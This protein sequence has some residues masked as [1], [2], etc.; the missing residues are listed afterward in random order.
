MAYGRLL[1]LFRAKLEFDEN[2]RLVRWF[3][4]QCEFSWLGGQ[5]RGS[6][7]RFYSIVSIPFVNSE[8]AE[9]NFWKHEEAK[10]GEC[11]GD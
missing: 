5:I 6:F 9:H 11:T 4:W 7:S 3:L 1:D 10:I 2:T 8:P